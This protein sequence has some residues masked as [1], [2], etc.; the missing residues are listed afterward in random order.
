MNPDTMAKLEKKNNEENYSHKY[1]ERSGD[2]ENQIKRREGG[3]IEQKKIVVRVEGRNV[4][5][6]Q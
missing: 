5:S 6:S 1:S 4:L 3:G 2:Y